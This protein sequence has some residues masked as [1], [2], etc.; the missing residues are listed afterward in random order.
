[1]HYMNAHVEI[2]PCALNII[3]SF[4]SEYLNTFSKDECPCFHDPQAITINNIQ[5]FI[6]LYYF[7]YQLY[8]MAWLTLLC[9]AGCQGIPW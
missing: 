6:F 1:M 5:Y 3:V 7:F 9:I 4:L 2:G 8:S